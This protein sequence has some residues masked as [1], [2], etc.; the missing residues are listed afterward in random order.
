MAQGLLLFLAFLIVLCTPSSNLQLFD[1]LPFSRLP[2]FAALVIALSFLIFPVL[3]GWQ[4]EFWARWKIRPACL[5]VLLAAVLV[6]KMAFL[7]SGEHAGFAGCYRSS[8]EPTSITHEDLPA[9]E[10]ERSYENPFG[11]FA[12]T[13]LDPSIW[14]GQDGWNLVFLNTDRYNYYDWEAGNILRPRIPI[15]AEWSGYPDIPPGD[16][17][18]IEYVGEGAVIWGDVRVGLPPA[19]AESNVVEVDPPREESLLQIEYSFDDGSRSGQ[20]SES[21]GPRASIKVS[22]AGK[23]STVRLAARS[24]PAGWRLLALLADGLIFLWALSCLPAFWQFLRSDLIP[25][26]AFSIGIGFFSLVPAAPVIRG[27]GITC[28]M[29]AALIAHLAL[30]PLRAVAIYF[31]VVAAGLAILRVWS[32]GLG[33][34][35]LRSAG[36][37]PLSYESQAYS[38]LAT[39]SLRGGESVFAYIPAYRYIKFLEHALFGDGNMLYAAVQLAAYFGGVFWLFRGMEK[40]ALPVIRKIVLAGLGC[41][42]IFLG[43]YYVSNI[44]REGL[45][46]YDTWILLLWALPGLYGVA[47]SGVILAGTIALSVSYTI[48]PNQLLGILW[49]LFLVVTGSWKKHAKTILLAGV[50]AFGI[51]L[52]PFVHNI[53]FGR[54]WVLAAT[55]GG[56]SV[57]L[58]L[59]P[60]TWLA[61]FQGDPAVTA[62][63]REQMGMLFLITDAPRSML[64]TLAVMAVFFF[65]WLAV[66]GWAIARRRVSELPWLAVPVFFLA[67]HL[68]YGLSTYY[69]RHIVIAYL[70]MAIT[71][72][73]AL[74]QGPWTVPAA[75][76][77]AV[78]LP[79]K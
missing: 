40:R 47:A 8:A 79:R 35:L 15:E 62:I 73:S 38:I 63:V 55:S 77:G 75:A 56:M 9:W 37:D 16:R 29:G 7:F 76:G 51:A 42:L 68:L 49:I 44:I 34:V 66:A 26:I 43:G 57:N 11:R 28:V 22:P 24:A 46:E 4:K 69:P 53:Y 13:R 60:S 52:L 17:I 64:P 20:D 2:E 6:I 30:R 31:I 50:L 58:I 71:A 39:F 61:F 33:Q 18:R 59:L 41:G 5:W 74:I 78:E 65:C 3:R 70:A 19:Y 14:F 67:I 1:G 54:E 23:D 36:N 25:L 72:V 48:R 27:I 10:C 21:W 45:S 32:F 12:A